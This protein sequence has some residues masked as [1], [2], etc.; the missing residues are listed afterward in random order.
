[1]HCLL[2]TLAVT[3]AAAAPPG[4]AEEDDPE[5]DIVVMGAREPIEARES[6]MPVT[7]VKA[8]ETR[9]GPYVPIAAD[10]LRG[11][12]GISVSVSGPRGSQTQ[13]RIRGAEAN[14]TLLFVDEI[15]FNDPAAGN[16]A[17]FELLGI[18]G[19]SRIDVIR[20]PQSALWGSEAIGGVVAAYT[21]AVNEGPPVQALAEY[22][23]LESY[24]VSGHGS[25]RSGKLELTAVAARLGSEGFD[26]FDGT[27]DRDGFENS[28]AALKAIFRPSDSVKLGAVGHWMTGESEYDGLDPLTFRRADTQDSTRNRIGAVR[29]WADAE[30]GDWIGRI[31][32]SYLDSSNRNLL[33]GAPLNR[34]SGSRLTVGGQLTRDKGKHRVT[35]AAEHQ[36]ER[37]HARDQNFFGATD[38]DR[39]RAL[40][41]GIFEWAS[42]WRPWLSTNVAVRHDSFSAFRDSTTLRAGATV[43]PVERLNVVAAYGEGIA[44]PSFY[45]LYGFFPGAFTGNPALKPERSREWQLGAHWKGRLS[46]WLDA[47]TARLNDEIVDVF[48]PATFRSTTANATGTSRRRGIEAQAELRL[49]RSGSLALYYT[50]L[51]AEERQVAGGLAVREIRRPRHSASLVGH[52]WL[53]PVQISARIAWVGK[54]RDL[55]FDAFPARDVVLADYWLAAASLDWKLSK[56]LEAFVRTENAFDQTYQDVAGYRTEGRTVH[57]GLRLRLGD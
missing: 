24:R 8:E 6:V 21:L 39:S 36:A 42:D 45:D 33:G 17:R 27:G 49:G 40:D 7:S 26:S 53:G 9:P 31:E 16:E 35:L 5:R 38:Q 57:A 48:D 3:A 47:F 18:E 13:V 11:L 2:I 25:A 23:S 20:G 30:H 46:L 14:H 1:M 28:S 19:L 15:R 44:Q 41:A 32:A 4:P 51:D 12:P 52:K 10:A 37:F 54:R 56:K 55:D 43:K 34:T 22:G 29:G 50:W